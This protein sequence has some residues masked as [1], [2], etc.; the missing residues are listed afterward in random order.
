MILVDQTFFI[1][2]VWAKLN[3]INFV[4]DAKPVFV[5]LLTRHAYCICFVYHTLYRQAVFVKNNVDSARNLDVMF[6]KIVLFEQ[7][8]SS[9]SKSCLP[10]IC[11]LRRIRNTIH[12][13]AACTTATSLIHSKIDYCNSLLCLIYLQLKPIIVNLSWTLLLSPKHVY[14]I[15]LLLF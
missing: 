4:A 10:N 8:I 12:Q 11:D 3:W 9:I 7:H 5:I 15:T 6:D 1:E 14:F 2:I 13:T